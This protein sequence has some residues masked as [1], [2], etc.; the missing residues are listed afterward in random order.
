M[1]DLLASVNGNPN[2]H[3]HVRFA[4]GDGTFGAS[5]YSL[6]NTVNWDAYNIELG[7]FN[8]DGMTDLLASVNGN[9]NWHTHVRFSQGDVGEQLVK[10][11]N[12]L[13]VDTDIT[14][15]PLSDDTIYTK[16]SSASYPDRDYQGPLYVVSSVKVDNSIGGQQETTYEYSGARINLEGRGFLGFASVES[17]TE[18]DPVNNI[19]VITTTNYVQA[20]PFIG[21]V[22]SRTQALSNSKL[23][24]EGESVFT[25]AISTIDDF[26]FEVTETGL[27]LPTGHPGIGFPYA[28]KVVTDN[29]EINDAT[30]QSA[31]TTVTRTI[32]S[33]DDFGNA[34]GI[35]LT[36]SDGTDTFKT[37]TTNSYH[38]DET[39]WFIGQLICASVKQ[40]LPDLTNATRISG[41][42]Y[43]TTTGLLTKE[44]IEPTASDITE[45]TGISSCATSSTDSNITLST[46]YTYDDFG[47]RSTVTV[48]DGVGGIAARTTTTTW[49]E[50]STFKLASTDNG[51]FAIE[52]ENAL[53][54]KEYRDYDG[55]HGVVT[56]LEGPNGLD[57]DWE[58]DS[59]GRQTKE[60]RADSTETL[61]TREWCNGFNGETS[62]LTCPTITGVTLALGVTTETDGAPISTVYTDD[63]GRTVRS[64]TEA[65][66]SAD[67]ILTD[68]EYD[69]VGL[70]NK[71]SRP[72]HSGDTIYWHEQTYDAIGRVTQVID[73]YASGDDAETDT[74][75]DGL[76][77]TITNAE[78]QKTKRTLN[79][80][81]EVVQ[82]IQIIGS[83]DGAVCGTDD[84]CTDYTYDPF[85]NLIEVEDP[86]SNFTTNTYDI[87]GRKLTMDDP[88]MGD[89]TYEYDA[90]S[91][92]IEQED[93]KGQITLLDYD[94]LGRISNR[95]DNVDSASAPTTAD[96]ET[97]WTYDTSTTAGKG[98]LHTVKQYDGLA[99]G[100]TLIDDK[101]YT[102]DS[103][104]RLSS[105]V[106]GINNNSDNDTSDT[107][108]RYTFSQ[109]YDI[110]G[111]LAALTYPASVHHT[112]GLEVA[113]SY[114][115]T[116]Y[117]SKV[118]ENNDLVLDCED[119]GD[120]VYWEATAQNALGQV[121]AMSYDNGV[122]T[123]QGYNV[124]TG[125]LDT[126]V[127][128]ALTA[129]DRQD[130][131][132]SFDKLGNLESREDFRID[133]KEDF[134]YDDINRLTTATL[135]DAANS[136]S[137]LNTNSVTYDEL[138]NIKTKSGVSGTWLYG[139][140]HNGSG[141][142]CQGVGHADPGPHAV[143]TAN[144]Q[145]YCYDANGNL[146]AGY[147]HVQSRKREVSWTAY[148]KPEEIK[149]GTNLS[150]PDRTLTF[151]YG[152][153]RSRIKQI[154]DNGS[155]STT[156]Y[157]IDG[158]FEKHENSGRITYLHYIV[159]GG[160]PVVQYKSIDDTTDEEETLYLHR[161]HL[162]SVSLIT[163]D[164]GAIVTGSEQSYD[165]WGKR[166]NA[167]N[168]SDVTTQLTN[169][170][171]TRGF[172]NH[173]QLDD[174]SLVHMN[175]R[176]YDPEL[177]RF[178]SA[179]PIVQAPLNSQSYNR[180]TYVFN[181]PLSYTD[182]SGYECIGCSAG[183][184]YEDGAGE[185]R[186]N[187][188]ILLG[189]HAFN[190]WVENVEDLNNVTETELNAFVT[191]DE[192]GELIPLGLFLS[193][194]EVV[195]PVCPGAL[196]CDDDD[197]FGGEIGGNG[198]VDTSPDFFARWGIFN[199][200]FRLPGIVL[201][202]GNSG[203][204]TEGPGLGH[205][206]ERL[207]GYEP[208]SQAGRDAIQMIED[209][210]TDAAEQAARRECIETNCMPD[211]RRREEQARDHLI[212]GGRFCSTSKQEGACNAV[213]G[214]NIEQLEKRN[215]ELLKQCEIDKC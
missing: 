136:Y 201:V 37:E 123:N 102:Y 185:A 58:Y 188:T 97:V 166:R 34:T 16:G 178:M 171:S 133:R 32:D 69:A 5:V 60:I 92:L 174:V 22:S 13:G 137:T 81:G 190:E 177:G 68:I 106:T 125:L 66:A 4:Q 127:T 212:E 12:S 55:E 31:V 43:A 199:S 100:T 23:I 1:T 113:Y 196:G 48:D 120:T 59:F 169:A 193:N 119:A 33:M 76:V 197:P 61:I 36:Q 40:T 186:W 141:E 182:P 45:P 35:T 49:G 147:N 135:K 62:S 29:Y 15:K 173:E 183:G 103:N 80:R 124:R 200:T 19:D 8:G 73:P 56:K 132:Y 180:Y 86:V 14:Y 3:T 25:S 195:E 172:T 128:T 11:T 194:D 94:K 114:T 91:Q 122:D 88:D 204:N 107:G 143:T 82:V 151:T 215:N 198:G 27:N 42:E 38:N 110:D 168:W 163:D 2:W 95:K 138:G 130:L 67:T 20:Y 75:Y 85:G 202:A 28:N 116:G 111:R 148:N 129:G 77:T 184:G 39:N 139:D 175:G 79:A 211:F 160:H 71:T 78:G 152:A 63:L 112:G 167:S 6:S 176:V 142:L 153:D 214:I 54:H 83:E 164:T 126:I 187:L 53:A 209:L 189:D 205:L 99:S 121:T 165:A 150:S 181:N 145:D 203:P 179:D 161:D 10:I 89:W 146:T 7:D 47:N 131:Q 117:L 17:T 191:T 57:T 149:E 52:I 41:F 74:T 64:E 24:S 162:G 51:R 87:R 90:L 118:C 157:Y 109:S 207:D 170:D 115:T 101:T 96:N 18:S 213:I 30:P 158:L 44:V 50:W 208:T 210:K 98:K 155:T 104:G 159:A 46:T 70:V 154:N 72:Y 140:Y 192:S 105:T 84:L 21:M 156:R 206:G 9:P 26:S 144:S 108:E 93:A 65:F 134:V